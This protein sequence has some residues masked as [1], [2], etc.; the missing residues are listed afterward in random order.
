MS[1]HTKQV[2]ACVLG[3][4]VK[5]AQ[6]ASKKTR[7]C[8]CHCPAPVLNFSDKDEHEKIGVIGGFDSND[9]L[10]SSLKIIQRLPQSIHIYFAC[11]L[12]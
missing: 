10:I 8:F 4:G 12:S 6:V 9:K 7:T 11:Y 5:L 3:V 2:C 1:A